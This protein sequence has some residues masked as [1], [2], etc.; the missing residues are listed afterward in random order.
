VI[1][2]EGLA[3]HA[4]LQCKPTMQFAVRVKGHSL[5]VTIAAAVAQSLANRVGIRYRSL[6][7]S[8][9]VGLVAHKMAAPAARPV[10]AHFTPLQ[11]CVSGRA[12]TAAALN[13]R[14]NAPI[15]HACDDKGSCFAAVALR[16][17]EA[18]PLK[19]RKCWRHMTN[20]VEY[21]SVSK[22]RSHAEYKG[23]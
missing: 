7:W 18:T 5:P 15:R 12:N 6:I 2:K 11:A 14:D 23:T 22:V 13:C 3:A 17:A 9:C 16:A 4:C 10:A 20:E 1:S 21:S 19:R 8:I